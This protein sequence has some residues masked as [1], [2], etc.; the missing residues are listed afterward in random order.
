MGGAEAWRRGKEEWRRLG[1]SHDLLL[2]PF[3]EAFAGAGAL[4]FEAQG[5]LEQGERLAAQGAFGMGT[6]PAE[7]G[8]DV[9]GGHGR[10][11]MRV[12]PWVLRRSRRDWRRLARA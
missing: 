8:G 11:R 4:G 5:V 7:G 3:L 12:V 6:V 9:G 2:E 1:P 10:W